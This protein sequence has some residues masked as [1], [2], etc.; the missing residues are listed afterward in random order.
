MSSFDIEQGARQLQTWWS[1]S[2]R[3]G[4]HRVPDLVV[5]EFQRVQMDGPGFSL[6]A[7]PLESSDPGFC[8]MEQRLGE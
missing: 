4:G 5:A 1:R 3:P 6:C 7:V 2:S 8:G